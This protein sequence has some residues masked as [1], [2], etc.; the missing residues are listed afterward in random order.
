[1]TT[2]AAAT[3]TETSVAQL[4][5]IVDIHRGVT[6]LTQ[7]GTSYHPHA[8][9]ALEGMSP[10]WF[11]VIMPT[12]WLLTMVDMMSKPTKIGRGC[13]HYGAKY[14]TTGAYK[15]QPHSAHMYQRQQSNVARTYANKSV[16]RRTPDGI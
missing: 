2:I 13:N 1:M 14:K 6:I 11:G 12:C 16:T 8:Y 10:G 9:F 7:A 15:Y 5:T 4:H 3:T